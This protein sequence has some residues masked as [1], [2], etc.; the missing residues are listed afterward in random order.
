MAADSDRSRKGGAWSN[1]WADEAVLISPSH[2]RVWRSG[3]EVAAHI[4]Q[5]R[6]PGAGSPRSSL[7]GTFVPTSPTAFPLNARGDLDSAYGILAAGGGEGGIRTL[8][9]A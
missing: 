7:R 6:T 5:E 3:I 2:W 4:Y 1:V 8:D 9:T